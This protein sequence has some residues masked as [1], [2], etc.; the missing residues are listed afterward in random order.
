MIIIDREF[1]YPN[2]QVINLETGQIAI[3]QHNV[4]VI[5]IDIEGVIK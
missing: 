4:E 3:F 5:P 2:M 1:K